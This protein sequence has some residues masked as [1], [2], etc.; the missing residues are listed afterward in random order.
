MTMVRL[1]DLNTTQA[2]TAASCT[3]VTLSNVS[4]RGNTKRQIGWIEGVYA[5]R[6][7]RARCTTLAMP[8][9]QTTRRFRSFHIMYLVWCEKRAIHNALFKRRTHDLI[10]RLRVEHTA[11][12][13][14]KKVI[15]L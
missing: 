2:L 3:K 12:A 8:Q 6:R 1:L 10:P 5:R 7:Q 13:E 4:V 11:A 15:V 9:N 14:P